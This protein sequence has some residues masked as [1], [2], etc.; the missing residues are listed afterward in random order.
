M[1]AVRDNL[2][3]ARNG[4]RGQTLSG[5]HVIEAR[6]LC[7]ANIAKPD[8][9]TGELGYLPCGRRLTRPQGEGLFVWHC[10]RHGEMHV[11]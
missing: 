1:Y 11:A 4:R 3:L 9:E 10:T 6:P 8:P 7:Q 2:V 5:S